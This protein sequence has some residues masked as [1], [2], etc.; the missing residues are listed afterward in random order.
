[1]LLASAD[2]LIQRIIGPGRAKLDPVV[3]PEPRNRGIVQNDLAD[4]GQIDAV[5]LLRCPLAFHIKAARPVQGIA[6]EIQPY[7]A[8]LTGWIYVDDPTPNGVVARF[9]HGRGLGKSH[10]HKECPK[11]VFVDPFIHAR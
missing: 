8:G 11:R 6:E 3:L 5:Q 2:S 10:P 4:R 9:G 7:G 1:M